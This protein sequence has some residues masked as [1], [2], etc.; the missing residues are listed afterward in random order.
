MY[1]IDEFKTE[2]QRLHHPSMNVD[3]DFAFYH[4][5]YGELLRLA[6]QHA[7]HYDDAAILSLLLYTENTIAIGLDGVYEYMYRS[8]GDVVFHWCDG[9]G[10]DANATSQV[11]NLVSQAVA[12]APCCVLRQWITESVL[13]REFQHLS[14]MLTYFAREDNNL[15]CIFPDLRYRKEMFL[16][17]SGDEHTARQM[18]WADMAFNWR[19]KHSNS[20][21][22]TLAKQCRMTAP[23]VDRQEKASLLE[24]AS[25][26]D[27]IRPERLDL[28]TVIE[29][30]NSHTLTLRHKN[31]RIFNNVKVNT[32]IPAKAQYSCL[33]AQLVTFSGKTYANG[34]TVWLNADKYAKWNCDKMWNDILKN[35]QEAAKRTYF[36]TPFG[37]RISLYEDLYIVP[38]DPEEAC[39]ADMGIYMDEPNIFDFL[40]WLKPSGTVSGATRL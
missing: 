17:I 28:Y 1:T 22:A 19:D 33:A 20:L 26:L 16:R 23:L 21:S 6:K 31:G 5:L 30:E 36:T 9:L 10:M 14:D 27:S 11:H 4:Q 12:D 40:E 8:L 24:A 15:R 38:E 2:W 13:S 7:R 35:E 3:G 32:P 18:L 29:K 34:P 37:K 25:I 39:Y